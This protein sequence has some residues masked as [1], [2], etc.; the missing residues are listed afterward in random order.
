[1]ENGPFQFQ[2]RIQGISC[3]MILNQVVLWTFLNA[4]LKHSFW[5][6]LLTCNILV[7]FISFMFH[8]C[9]QCLW[10][11][12][13]RRYINVLLLL[14][15][16][17]L[18]NDKAVIYSNTGSVHTSSLY[19]QNNFNQNARLMTELQNR[20]ARHLVIPDL[21]DFGGGIQIKQPVILLK[22]DLNKQ[23]MVKT[24]SKYCRP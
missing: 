10:I 24:F 19:V 15:L 6:E 5:F 11:L 16:L 23:F 13:K 8:S 4:N 17:L 12:Q 21:K 18:L 2:L 20:V 3:Y 1:M 7:K 14:L 22:Q 9:E